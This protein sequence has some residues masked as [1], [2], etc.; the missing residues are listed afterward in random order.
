MTVALSADAE[1]AMRSWLRAVVA[2]ADELCAT[3]GYDAVDVLG[4]VDDANAENGASLS[5]AYIALVGDNLNLQVGLTS[6]AGGCQTLAKALLGM[7]P[8]DDD[9]PESDVADAVGEI[10]NMIGGGAKRI[11]SEGDSSLK[12]GLPLFINGRILETDHL[13]AAASAVR[14]GTT[15]ARLLVLRH[16][17]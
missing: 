9:L 16:R 14:I 5:G 2:A 4:A 8:D 17:V 12:L 6:S 3:I 7:E 13:E 11:M 15:D 10:V 1:P